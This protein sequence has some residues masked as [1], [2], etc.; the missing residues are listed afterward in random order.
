MRILLIGADGQIGRSLR[1]TLKAAGDLTITKRSG[2]AND[3]PFETLDVSR[4][5]SIARVIAKCAPN[6]VVNAAGYT[7]VDRAEV[8][9]DLA[10]KVNACAPEAMAAACMDIDATL[11][12]FSTDYVFDGR[13]TCPYRESDPTGPLSAYGRSKLAGEQ[14]ILAS[15]ARALVLRT[16]WVYAAYGQNFLLT[17]L[18]LAKERSTLNVV[19]DQVG[20]PTAASY[21]A[22]VTADILRADTR[23]VGLYHLTGQGQTSWHG[24]AER[25][26]LGAVARGLLETAPTLNPIPSSDYP[27]PAPRPRYSCLDNAC[28]AKTFGILP[29]PWQDGV[30]RVLDELRQIKNAGV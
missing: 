25:I 5:S 14:A 29:E 21:I 3:F 20:S 4:P 11:V 28:I 7:A 18:R 17:M 12:H 6:V 26:M 13:S 2:D 22:K 19:G 23:A 10:F 15:G 9:S 16:A 24:F 30:E 1:T 27:T 8:E